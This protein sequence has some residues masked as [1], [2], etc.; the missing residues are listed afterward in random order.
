MANVVSFQFHS[1]PH[2]LSFV[3][4]YIPFAF[5]AWRCFHIVS[6]CRVLGICTRV[7]YSGHLV[8]SFCARAPS[9]DRPG[10]GAY[11]YDSPFGNRSLIAIHLW[12]FAR[13]KGWRVPL[14]FPCVEHDDSTVLEVARTSTITSR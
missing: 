6:A 8:H 13:P 4:L 7:R 10:S 12:C 14:T 9:L 5:C 11:F 1:F 2:P 3:L